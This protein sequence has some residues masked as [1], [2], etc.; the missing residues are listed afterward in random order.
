[1]HFQTNSEASIDNSPGRRCST[2]AFPAI[3]VTSDL[4]LKKAFEGVSSPLAPAITKINGSLLGV[5]SFNRQSLSNIERLIEQVI[6][7]PLVPESVVYFELERYKQALTNAKRYAPTELENQLL[8]AIGQ[9]FDNEVKRL[10][11]IQPYFIKSFEKVYGDIELNYQSGECLFFNSNLAYEAVF[12]ALDKVPEPL[13]AAVNALIMILCRNLNFGIVDYEVSHT[14]IIQEL[15]EIDGVTV[16]LV[17]NVLTLINEFIGDSLDDFKI[18]LDEEDCKS[19]EFLEGILREFDG[20]TNS[21]DEFMGTLNH[22]LVSEEAEIF[23]D[24]INHS[25]LHD[26]S[27]IAWF[28]TTLTDE[29]RCSYPKTIEWLEESCE[30]LMLCDPSDYLHQSFDTCDESPLFATTMIQLTSSEDVTGYFDE[31]YQ[32]MMGSDSGVTPINWGDEM[33]RDSLLSLCPYLAIFDSIPS[34]IQGGTI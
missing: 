22:Y 5:N 6:A 8:F 11:N 3:N 15:K 25:Y 2:S 1:M 26:P 23:L 12:L 32:S 4:A 18:S 29:V 27:S 7:E 16:P 30:L 17:T 24:G 34:E 31:V 21:L 10:S 33:Q 9:R 13:A 28:L 14:W 20:E 19:V